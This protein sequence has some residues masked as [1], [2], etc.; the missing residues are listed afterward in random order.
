MPKGLPFRLTDYLELVDWAGRILRED[1]WGSIAQEI[2]SILERHQI[3]PQH[4]RY[5]TT[6]FES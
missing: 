1:K 3:E 6:S 2:P 4:W 5:L